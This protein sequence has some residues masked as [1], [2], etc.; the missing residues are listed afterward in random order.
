[1]DK[2]FNLG[3][4]ASSVLDSIDSVAKETLEEP[5]VSAT[6]LRSKRRTE[7]HSNLSQGNLQQLDRSN[8]QSE[9]VRW[10]SCTICMYAWMLTDRSHRMMLVSHRKKRKKAHLNNKEVLAMY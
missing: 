1:M 3:A 5:K 2:M 10:T 8:S 4:L 7:N 6:V 9:K